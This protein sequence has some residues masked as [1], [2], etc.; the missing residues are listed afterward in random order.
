MKREAEETPKAQDAPCEFTL[1]KPSEILAMSF[2]DSD[3]ILGDRLLA[4]TQ[5]FTICGQ[6]GIGKSRLLLQLAA[7]QILGVA[8]ISLPTHGRPRKWLIIQTENSNRRLRSDFEKLKQWAG[9]RW[10]EID[11]KLLIHTL[12]TDE[13]SLVNIESSEGR[14]RAAIKKFQP[15]IVVFDPLNAFSLGDL[16]SDADMRWVCLKLAQI[17]KQGNANRALV[18]LHHSL[19]GRAGAAKATGFDRSSFGRNSKVL[20]ALTRAQINLAPGS[21]TDNETLVVSCGKNSNGR[22]FPPF[23]VRLNSG[24]MIYEVVRDFNFDAWKDAIA[25]KPK[26]KCTAEQMAALVDE[27]GNSK[28]DLVK[29]AEA[30]TKVSRAQGNRVVDDAISKGLIRYDEESKRCFPR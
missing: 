28:A 30:Q 17:V 5:L 8:F 4:E 21:E 10:P 25:G 27:T 22:E 23:A 24:T 15:D 13:D 7:C 11:D 9:N 20:L 26:K 3:M 14:I 12:E 6:G 29:K 19:T 2:G 1:R 16:N 18:V